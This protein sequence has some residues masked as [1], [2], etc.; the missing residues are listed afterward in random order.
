[1]NAAEIRTTGLG[2]LGMI[3][4]GFL[5]RGGWLIMDWLVSHF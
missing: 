5:F 2:W 1:M 3:V 4:T